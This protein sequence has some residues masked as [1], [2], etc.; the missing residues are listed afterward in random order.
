MIDRFLS[1]LFLRDLSEEDLIRRVTAIRKRRA[2]IEKQAIDLKGSPA[3]LAL[4][5]YLFLLSAG[6]ATLLWTALFP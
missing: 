2:F 4:S 6:G 5:A 3:D 1:H